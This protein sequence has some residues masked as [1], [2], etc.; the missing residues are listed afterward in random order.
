MQA[1]L[2]RLVV[3]IIAVQVV[4]ENSANNI[5]GCSWWPSGP[6]AQL[7][8]MSCRS[9]QSWYAIA[10]LNGD[11]PHRAAP[12]STSRLYAIGLVPRSTGH[13]RSLYLQRS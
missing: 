7:R 1:Q 10:M 5:G 9:L 6:V 4:I 12:P 8:H 11:E 3:V 13:L 2:N